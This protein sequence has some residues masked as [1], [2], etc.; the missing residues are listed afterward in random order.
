M[1]TPHSQD[2][3]ETGDD[4][5]NA[6]EANADD[7]E[8]YAEDLRETGKAE[9][10]ADDESAGDDP[11]FGDEPILPSS[12]VGRFQRNT[13]SGAVLTGIALG[14]RDIFDPTVKEEA[15]IVQDAPG[16]PPNP[17][18]VTADLDPDD[19]AASSVTVRPWLAASEE[20]EA[21]ELES[22][23]NKDDAL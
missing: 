11:D 8:R 4:E 15:P 20:L 23:S 7:A 21:S 10:F 13:S 12:R 1:G 14:L 19:P 17:R 16:E 3:T 18:H 22:E 6:D 9:E 2:P 5:P